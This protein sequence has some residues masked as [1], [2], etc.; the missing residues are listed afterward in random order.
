MNWL[1]IYFALQAGLITQ[2]AE[3]SQGGINLAWNSPYHSV[4]STLSFRAEA[5][6]HIRVKSFV[7]TYEAFSTSI[8]SQGPFNPYRADYGIALSLYSGPFEIGVSHEC[9]HVVSLPLENMNSSF[10]G[11]YSEVFFRF[12][13]K[14][15]F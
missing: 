2:T 5:F 4:E 7:R 9:D 11:G 15:S 6:D 1:V 8:L 13:A 3:I 12:Q 10:A 14:A